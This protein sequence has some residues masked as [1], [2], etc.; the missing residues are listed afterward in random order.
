MHTRDAILALPDAKILELAHQ[1]CYAY[2]LKRVMRYKTIRDFS[3][4]SESDAEHI[5][6]L[7]YLLEY[8]LPLEDPQG[9]LDIGKIRHLILYHDFTEIKHGD[10]PYHMKTKEDEER[11]RAAAPEVFAALPTPL[12]TVGLASWQEYEQRKTPEA[13]FVYALDKIEPLFELLDPVN[14]KSFKR[15]GHTYESHITKKLR[16]TGDFPTM[17]RFIEVVSADMRKR[18]VFTNDGRE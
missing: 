8:F 4:H 14:E 2:K 15:L 18:K 13:K 5:F 6:G 12:N 16:A 1:L 10:K 3:V 9:E 7:S 17:R 11:E